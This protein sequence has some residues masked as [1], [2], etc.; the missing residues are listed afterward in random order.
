MMTLKKNR[1]INTTLLFSCFLSGSVVAQIEYFAG[2]NEQYNS[3]IAKS[4]ISQSGLES[5]VLIGASGQK[6]QNKLDFGV[7][8]TLSHVERN[9][10]VIQTTS[11]NLLNGSS[12]L[13]VA[14]I[15]EQFSWLSSLNASTVQRSLGTPSN[16]DNLSN[17][18]SFTTQPQYRWRLNTL[19]TVVIKSLY[20]HADYDSAQPNVDWISTEAAL[21]HIIENG[22]LSI[23]YAD[24]K[25]DFDANIPGIAKRDTYVTANKHWR[26]LALNAEYGLVSLERKGSATSYDSTRYKFSS[27]VISPRN[28]SLSLSTER[29]YTDTLSEMAQS[30]ARFQNNLLNPQNSSDLF[31]QQAYLNGYFSDLMKTDTYSLTYNK[32]FT[33]HSFQV[34]YQHLNREAINTI[35]LLGDS[36]ESVWGLGLTRLLNQQSNIAFE[37]NNRS[38]EFNVG[39]TQDVELTSLSYNRKL[40][41][42]FDLMTRVSHEQGEFSLTNISYDDNSILLSLRYVG[43][44]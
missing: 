27:T 44:L 2:V 16:A 39:L 34:N 13:N 35:S 36:K 22:L 32:L 20:G 1:L 21:E 14:F 15:P 26:R 38:T 43:I 41:R 7:N 12:Y 3:N 6:T 37:Y 17:I 24:E 42:H 28:S 23:A 29:N 31:S 5:S 30:S 10:G 40:S 19:N 4:T 25:R 8:G 9:G 11:D 33:S 18:I